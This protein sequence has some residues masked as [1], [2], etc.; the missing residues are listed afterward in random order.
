MFSSCVS[1]D[2]KEKEIVLERQTLSERREV[3]QHE[4][5]RL[6]DGQALLN[7][8]ED[9]VASKSQELSCIEK[10]L[11]ASK[12]SIENELRDLNDRKSNLEVTVASLSQREEVISLS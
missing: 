2:A 5:E 10:E 7:Q 9:Y 4:H 1:C 8:R 12:A 6:L 11:E 3:L